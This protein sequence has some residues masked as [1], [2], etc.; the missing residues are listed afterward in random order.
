VTAVTG[1]HATALADVTV[2]IPGPRSATLAQG[3][4]F[5][6]P[7][8]ASD[9]YTL[10]P[11]RVVDTRTGQAPALAAYERRV[12]TATGGACGVPASATAVSLNVTVTGAAASGHIRLAP[13]NGLTE[14]SAINFLPGV[15]RA[16]NGIVRLATDGTGG[17]SAT[18]RSGGPVHL[19]VDVNGYFE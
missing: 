11:C 9:F 10:T 16:N 3:F 15:N 7:V 14:S 13:G 2:T 6:P 17:L 19:V 4:F 1:A 8:T 5:V 18:N 12:F